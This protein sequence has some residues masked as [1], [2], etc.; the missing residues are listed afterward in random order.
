MCSY[1][2]GSAVVVVYMLRGVSPTFPFKVGK[3][4]H[5]F[6]FVCAKTCGTAPVSAFHL[7]AHIVAVVEDSQIKIVVKENKNPS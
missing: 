7:L 5:L 2:T 1:T 4:Q 6:V 3:R